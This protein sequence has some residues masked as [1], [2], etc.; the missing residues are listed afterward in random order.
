MPSSRSLCSVCGKVP[1]LSFCTGCEKVFCPEHAEQHRLDLASLLD[2][3]VVDHQQCK[4][5]LLHFTD[6]SIEHPLMKQISD[7]ECQSIEKIQQ[8]GQE[9]RQQVLT[10]LGQFASNTMKTLTGDL[11]KAQ[12]E[13]NF[14]ERDLRQ[15]M[16]KLTKIKKEL[17]KP[18]TVQLR[19]GSEDHPLISKLLVNVCEIFEQSASKTK[20]SYLSTEE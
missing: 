5:S 7:W 8:I 6:Q 1:S 15:W 20:A 3:I 12:H 2:K 13:D 14:S 11:S 9:C 19:K 16:D 17:D 10:V 4:A 18:P